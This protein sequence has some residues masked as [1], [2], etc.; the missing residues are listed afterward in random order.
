RCGALV[1]KR[2]D[3]RP[4]GDGLCRV[5]ERPER[6]L[7][8]R[9]CEWCGR[10][11]SYSGRGRPRR[12]CSQAHRQRAYEL[13][14]ALAR[15]DAD[16]AAGRARGAEEPVREVV[17][18]TVVRTTTRTVRGP[19]V[20]V[21]VEVER[22]VVPTRAREVQEVLEAAAAAV[23]AGRIQHWDHRRLWQGVT[24]LMAA[25]DATHPGGIDTLARRR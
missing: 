10:E 8:S 20:E 21:P 6:T 15:R 3:S 12:Y 22:P 9:R 25:L 2:S 13:R 4:R 1:L 16:R 11:M 5:T 17:R 23:M 18:E 24:R 19:V 7:V 14:T